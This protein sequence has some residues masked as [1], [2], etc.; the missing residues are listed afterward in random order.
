VKREIMSAAEAFDR[1]LDAVVFAQDKSEV[2]S[3]LGLQE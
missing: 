1:A 3:L 2:L